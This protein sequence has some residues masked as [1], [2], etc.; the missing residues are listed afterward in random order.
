MRE[1]YINQLIMGHK[2]KIAITTS[3]QQVKRKEMT[4]HLTRKKTEYSTNAVCAIETCSVYLKI[5][6]IFR[7]FGEIARFQ[8][9]AFVMAIR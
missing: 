1:I 4:Q 3:I 9:M 5:G 2:H 7:L 8:C 6:H